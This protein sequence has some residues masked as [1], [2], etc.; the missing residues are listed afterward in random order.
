MDNYHYKYAS[1]I[2]LDELTLDSSLTRYAKRQVETKLN[3]RKEK[4]RAQLFIIFDD[5]NTNAFNKLN[6]SQLIIL[7]KTI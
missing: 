3:Q 2:M 5:N 7:N 4:T 6:T 1:E